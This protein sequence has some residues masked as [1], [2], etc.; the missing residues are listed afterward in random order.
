MFHQVASRSPGDDSYF[1]QLRR[2]PTAVAETMDAD[3]RSGAEGIW[4]GW[5][6]ELVGSGQ[7]PPGGA[8]ALLHHSDKRSRSHRP[9]V[10]SPGRAPKAFGEVRGGSAEVEVR[11]PPAAWRPPFTTA[12]TERGPIDRGCGAVVGRR[13][14]LERLVAGASGL[15]SVALQ[16]RGGRPSPQRQPTAIPRAE[17]AGPRSGT[18]GTW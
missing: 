13:R 4:I 14:H 2:R 15:W 8:S 11:G 9:W 5:W 7:R 1:L 10:W 17:C 12:T 16:R 3:P 18:E 6:R